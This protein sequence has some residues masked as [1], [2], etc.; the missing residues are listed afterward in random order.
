MVPVVRSHEQFRRYL[1]ASKDT[2]FKMET[3]PFEGRNVAI[4]WDGR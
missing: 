3:L 1:V 2:R 4:W